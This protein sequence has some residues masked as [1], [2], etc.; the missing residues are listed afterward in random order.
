[1]SAR[2]CENSRL[3]ISLV[4]LASLRP[5]SLSCCS[6]PEEPGCIIARATRR[7]GTP[8]DF[9]ALDSRPVRRTGTIAIVRISRV[10]RVYM[11]VYSA[12]AEFRSP[13]L[14]LRFPLRRTLYTRDAFRALSF[15]FSATPSEAARTLPFEPDPG[16]I[17]Y[18]NAI[19]RKLRKR[20]RARKR[21]GARD[22]SGPV[23]GTSLRFKLISF[24]C[25]LNNATKQIYY[26]VKIH[27][28]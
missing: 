22:A 27:D 26:F 24:S 13:S 12:G 17:G 19:F 7:R 3:P 6:L 14:A 18:V 5:S 23:V 15:S 20:A 28:A 16:R 8:L 10:I 1:M 2:K 4:H 11:Y 25:A 21:L 9:I